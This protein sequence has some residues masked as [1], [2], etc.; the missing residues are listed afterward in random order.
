MDYLI[1]TSILKRQIYIGESRIAVAALIPIALSISAAIILNMVYLRRYNKLLD[2]LKRF[3]PKLH[4]KLRRKPDVG[5]LY[6][7]GYKHIK[8]LIA[9]TNQPKIQS[10]PIA[11]K[12][13]I[14]FLS[15]DQKTTWIGIAI[16][17]TGLLFFSII[18]IISL[19]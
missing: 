12:M 3:H 5:L 9:L 13:L 11:K 17:I 1:L 4:E 6:S 2:Y 18:S 15:F 7:T 10:D 19:Y 14:E 16:G 8:P